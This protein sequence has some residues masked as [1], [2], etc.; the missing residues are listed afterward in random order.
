MTWTPSTGSS[1]YPN[2]N[3]HPDNELTYNTAVNGGLTDFYSF[4]PLPAFNGDVLGTILAMK[5]K[6][7]DG[8]SA[9]IKGVYKSGMTLVDSA[10][11]WRPGNTW[12]YKIDCLDASPFT[13]H[14]WTQAEL[15]APLVAGIERLS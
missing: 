5:V 7:T 6:K 10:S 8:G 4:D 15:T 9:Q 12:R 13:G 2:V 1:N 14:R 3:V 11:N